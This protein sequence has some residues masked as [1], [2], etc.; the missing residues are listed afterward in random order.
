MAYAAA[1]DAYDRHRETHLLPAYGQESHLPVE[2]IF[3]LEETDGRLRMARVQ[4]ARRALEAPAPNL[5]GLLVKLRIATCELL[6]RDECE[7]WLPVMLHTLRD[8]ER[9]IGIG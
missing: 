3:A 1:R 6:E 4:S 2:T 8:A 5:P 7:D 9:L